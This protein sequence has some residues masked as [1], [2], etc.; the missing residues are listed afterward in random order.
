MTDTSQ[1]LPNQQGITSDCLFNLKPSA[2]S[3]RSYRCS[4]PTSNKSTFNPGDVAIA[5]I[6]ARRNCFLDTTQSYIRYTVKNGDTSVNINFDNNGASVINRLDVFHGS[7]LLET[8]QAYNVLYTYLLDFNLNFATRAGLSS[9]YGIHPDVAAIT[10]GRQGAKITTSNSLTV[11]MPLLSGTVGVL[12]DKM[13]PLNLADDIRLEFS[14][15]SQNLGMAYAAT[16]SSGLSWSIISMELELCIVE[17]SETGMGMIQSITPFSQPV[18][19]HG[20]SYRHYVSTFSGNGG[21]YSTLVP[22][23]FA[24][25]KSLILCPRRNTEAAAANAYSISSRVN[26]AIQSYWWRVGSIIVPQK[27][28]TLQ[29]SSNTANYSEAFAEIQ[30][31]FHAL[32]HA[33]Y[34]GSLGCISYNI[35][36]LSD[37]AVG[38]ASGNK[39]TVLSPFT[40]T[41]SYK[42]GFA[43]S[44]ELESFAQRNDTILSGMNTLG[45]QVF[46][47]ANIQSAGTN[48][49][50]T[51]AAYTLDFYAYYD[52]ILILQDGL[53]SAKF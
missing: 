5:Y 48:G 36:D 11:C 43:I 8:V 27:S 30:K 1:F 3:S 51:L 40:T 20:T 34:S 26:P 4:V 41:N 21:A 45:S 24:S 49:T 18:F 23:R 33:E 16:P 32:N 10:D 46:F 17:M 22:A 37:N 13:L 28:I 2:V 19:L 6:P 39:C 53:L 14:I 35:C 7:N 50:G 44:V 42:N 25:L 38:D 29:N 15:E 9:M 12:A 52:M 47:E 31:S